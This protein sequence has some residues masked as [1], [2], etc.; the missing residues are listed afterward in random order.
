MTGSTK[1]LLVLLL[2]L[3]VGGAF[4]FQRNVKKEERQLRPYRGYSDS[5]LQALLEAYRADADQLA[6]RYG[7]VKTARSNVRGG[8]LIDEQV[9]QFEEIQERGA[10]VRDAGA[11]ISMR[12]ADIAQMEREILLRDQERDRLRHF[13]RRVATFD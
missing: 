5:D 3:A 12:E 7:A 8:G 9:R 6:K 10:Q 1:K 13:L 4:N 11:Q 2:I